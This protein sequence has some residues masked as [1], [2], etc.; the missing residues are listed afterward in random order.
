MAPISGRLTR[1]LLSGCEQRGSSLRMRVRSSAIASSVYD[2]VYASMRHWEES[3]MD[4]VAT[5]AGAAK[6]V[7]HLRL[8][9]E[10]QLSESLERERRTTDEKRSCAEKKRALETTADAVVRANHWELLQSADAR[11]ASMPDYWFSEAMLRAVRENAGLVHELE[12]T[13]QRLRRAERAQKQAGAQEKFLTAQLEVLATA[14]PLAQAQQVSD[15]AVDGL[16]EAELARCI[17]GG[18]GQFCALLAN[19]SAWK[20]EQD[21]VG[22]ATLAELHGL[23]QDLARF[24]VLSRSVLPDDA[25]EAATSSFGETTRAFNLAA[26]IRQVG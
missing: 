21:A 1:A 2:E 4:F 25:R 3:L 24:W 15:G 17:I 12:D 18:V 5:P 16:A 14:V 9:I 6:A 20:L 19:L 10:K 22:M 13:E 7:A 11:S 8:C 23:A 26:P